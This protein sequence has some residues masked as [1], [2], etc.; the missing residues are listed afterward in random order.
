MKRFHGLAAAAWLLSGLAGCS[1]QPTAATDAVVAPKP[2]PPQRFADPGKPENRARYLPRKPGE[3][4]GLDFEWT[5]AAY[6]RREGFAAYQGEL[7]FRAPGGLGPLLMVTPRKLYLE[8]K[9]AIVEVVC[10]AE[11]RSCT[12]DDLGKRDGLELSLPASAK[13]DGNAESFMIVPLREALE[14]LDLPQTVDPLS[15]W[16]GKRVALY[17]D[18]DVTFQLLLGVAYTLHQA[19]VP[20]LRFVGLG[21]RLRLGDELSLWSP[22]TGETTALPGDRA[23]LTVA[24]RRDH[25]DF[26]VSG[27]G[28]EAVPKLPKRDGE[29][30][31]FPGIYSRLASLKQEHLAHLLYV[32]AE[33]KVRWWDVA[34][35]IDAARWRLEAD[36]YSD[37]A[38]FAAAKPKQDAAGAPLPLFRDFTF[39]MAF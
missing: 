13:E 17:L 28:D 12:D 37:A 27:S 11:R 38:A 16:R 35:A 9:G 33:P 19:G 31:D 7:P 18:K 30:Y 23:G 29:G 26:Q 20:G 6:R 5:L 8:G 3:L 34:A 25:V 39:V 24:V 2:A 1:Q 36:E 32:G 4:D 21:G 14:E 22:R 10:T 15:G